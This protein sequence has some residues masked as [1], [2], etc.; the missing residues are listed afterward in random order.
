MIVITYTK[1]FSL[2]VVLIFLEKFNL[3][4]FL[5]CSYFYLILAL[6]FL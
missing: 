1:I 6:L 4:L 5:D 2:R 3:K